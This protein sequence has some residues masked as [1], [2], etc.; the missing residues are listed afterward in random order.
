VVLG[1]L[2]AVETR[3]LWRTYGDFMGG[4]FLS[5]TVA[6]SAAGV[7]YT[8]EGLVYSPGMAKRLV[9]LE[10]E[11]AFRAATFQRTGAKKS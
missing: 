7:V 3:G 10:M 4:P 8:L 1:G 5:Y 6:D 9:L 11:A 2:P